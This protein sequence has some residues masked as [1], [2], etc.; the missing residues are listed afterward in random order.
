MHPTYEEK[1]KK[2]AFSS[3]QFGPSTKNSPFSPKNQKN[4]YSYQERKMLRRLWDV[5]ISSW[6]Q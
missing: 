2:E 6:V 5:K 4:F 1:R 3:L